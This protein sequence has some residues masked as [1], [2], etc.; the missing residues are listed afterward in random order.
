MDAFVL[1]FCV[2]FQMCSQFARLRAGTVTLVTCVW[3]Y[4]IVCFQMYSQLE[5][6]DA[7]ADADAATADDDDDQSNGQTL[8]E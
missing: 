3:L 8:M 2:Q 7:D 1:L 6:A 5:D 4:S